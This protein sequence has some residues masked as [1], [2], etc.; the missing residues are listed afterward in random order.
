[1]ERTIE[2]AEDLGVG[3]DKEET[4]AANEQERAGVSPRIESLTASLEEKKREIQEAEAALRAQVEKKRREMEEAEV[5]LKEAQWQ[6]N[7]ER[8]DRELTDLYRE[9]RKKEDEI[10]RAINNAFAEAA[11]AVENINLVFKGLKDLKEKISGIESRVIR[12]DEG[13]DANIVKKAM[14]L[15]RAEI[16]REMEVAEEV[17]GGLSLVRE[18]SAALG[19]QAESDGEL[20]GRVVHRLP[21]YA[22][23]ICNELKRSTGKPVKLNRDEL[24]R[25]AR[26]PEPRIIKAREEL[27]KSLDVLVREGRLVFER[28]GE[29]LILRM[30]GERSF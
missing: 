1:M 4:K 19:L 18:V 8:I 22:Q 28:E 21:V 14:E 6:E 3:K 27:E 12:S 15:K 30:S 10:S 2:R 17:K 16:V 29:T 24:I 9:E 20:F 23:N 7:L 5:A 25:V 13:R 11:K 26:I